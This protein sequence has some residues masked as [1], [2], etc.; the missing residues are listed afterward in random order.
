LE[1]CLQAA[2][3]SALDLSV[4]AQVVN[5]LMRLQ[6]ELGL[7]I[8]AGRDQPELRLLRAASGLRPQAAGME[9]AA[10]RRH[11]R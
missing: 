5:L 10:G 11:H 4:R 6:R 2:R 8:M 1:R 7:S 3:V 9:A